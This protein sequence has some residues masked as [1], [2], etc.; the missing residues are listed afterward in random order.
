MKKNNLLGVFSSIIIVNNEKYLFQ[1]EIGKRFI[2]SNYKREGI[3][4]KIMNKDPITIEST[5]GQIYPTNYNNIIVD[6]LYGCTLFAI[7][8]D[9]GRP[10]DYD[11]IIQY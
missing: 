7:Y 8:Y 10:K 5:K 6:Y 3:I 1:E 4:L 2:E 9:A 11:G